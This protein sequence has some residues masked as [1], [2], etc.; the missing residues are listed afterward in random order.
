[1]ADTVALTCLLEEYRSSDGPTRIEAVAGDVIDVTPEKA[2]QL[3]ADFPDGFEPAKPA[4]PK[5]K[6]APKPKAKPTGS[7]S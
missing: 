1:M 4:A 6:P 5:A 7:T 2:E 3:L